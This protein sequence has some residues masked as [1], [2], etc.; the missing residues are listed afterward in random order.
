MTSFWAPTLY[1]LRKAIWEGAPTQ[2]SDRPGVVEDLGM[3]RRF[4]F[5]N[6]EISWPASAHVHSWHTGPHRGGEEP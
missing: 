1:V 2:A 3:C 6:R 4:L 5:G